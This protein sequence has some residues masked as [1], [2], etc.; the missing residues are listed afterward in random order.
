MFS[1]LLQTCQAKHMGEENWATMSSSL[2]T[3]PLTRSYNSGN[4]LYFF[5]VSAVRDIKLFFSGSLSVKD[6]SYSHGVR[7]TLYMLFNN[8]PGMH[9]SGSPPY[10]W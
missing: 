4:G 10:F 2:A 1:F 5:Q 6:V 9:S 8:T 7:Q 3:C